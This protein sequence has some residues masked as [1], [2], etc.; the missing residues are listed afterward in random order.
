[1]MGKERKALVQLKTGIYGD[2]LRH[3]REAT[4]KETP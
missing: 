3:C 2:I 1:M 4:H